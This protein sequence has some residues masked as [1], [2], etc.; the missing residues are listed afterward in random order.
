MIL[1][2]YRKMFMLEIMKNLPA[3]VVGVK[4]TGKVTGDEVNCVLTP[5]LDDL[6]ARKNEIHYLLHLDTD[7]SNWNI[8]AWAQ[9]AWSGKKHITRL[10]KIAVVS[11]Q[12]CIKKFTNVFSISVPGESKG[13]TT[14]QMEEAKMWLSKS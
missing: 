8:V 9:N 6:I 12:E 14:A 2:C 13:F 5:A 1:Q 7:I 11:D 3:H 4:A 10:T